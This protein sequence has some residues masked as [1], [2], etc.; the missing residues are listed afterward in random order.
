MASMHIGFNSG[1]R[2]KAAAHA[3]YIVRAGVYRKGDKAKD[4]VATGHGNLPLGIADPL[5][6][7]KAADKGERANAAAYREIVGALPR[8][9]TA[10]QQSELVEEFIERVIPNKP[11]QYAIHCPSA[12]LETGTQPHV[13]LMFTDRIPDGVLREPEVF[14]HRH[15]AQ[16]P[17]RGGCKKDSGGKDPVTFSNEA[18]LRRENWAT[19]QNEYLAKYGHEARVDPRSYRVRGLTKEVEKHLGAAAIRKMSGEDKAAFRSPPAG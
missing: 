3:Q 11:Y 2:G 1:K 14:F 16:H 7:W 5:S 15:N 10:A 18:K 6:L 12:S 9:L 13:H 4:L 8:E 17:E 19:V